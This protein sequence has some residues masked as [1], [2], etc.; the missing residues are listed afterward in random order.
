MGAGTWHHLAFTFGASGMKLFLDGTLGGQAAQT[1]GLTANLEAIVRGEQA[2]VYFGSALTNLGL[3]RLLDG[4]ARVAPAPRPATRTPSPNADP[5]G[6]VMVT[7]AGWLATYPLLGAAWMAVS[8]TS[9]QVN[10]PAMLE[11]CRLVNSDPSP[12]NVPAETEVA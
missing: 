5:A 10:R 8:V 2:P 12:W 11:A 7:G 3:R 1:G 6:R 4:F 9:R